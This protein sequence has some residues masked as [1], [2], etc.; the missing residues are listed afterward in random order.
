M[1]EPLDIETFAAQ[2]RVYDPDRYLTARLTPKASRSA[3]TTLYA[4]NVELSRIC[5]MV[6][7]PALGEIRLQ[8]WR[9]AIARAD[10][11]SETGAPLADALMQMIAKL[12]LPKP[13]LLGMIDARSADLDGGGFADLQALKAYLY[14]TDGALFALS[15]TVLGHS[16]GGLAKTANA[17]GVAYGLSRLLRVLP[18]DAAAGRIMLPLT[19]LQSHNVLPEQI[20]AG[21]EGKGLRDLISNLAEEAQVS[22]DEARQCLAAEPK[23]VR[24]IF[25]PLA[26]VQPYLHAIARPNRQQLHDVADINPLMRFFLLWRAART[27][28]L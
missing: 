11:S 4:F 25:A 10:G 2:L 24:G 12:G 16:G 26:L 18:H 5:D 9:D 21:T 19:T 6:S 27:R 8:W 17:A 14:K 13:L 20:L 22:L 23:G 28:R 7:E 15:A 3:L 1:T